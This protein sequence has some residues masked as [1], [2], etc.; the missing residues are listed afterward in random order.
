VSHRDLGRLRPAGSPL[1]SEACGGVAQTSRRARERD[2][3][4]I[5]E[6][7]KQRPKAGAR[8]TVLRSDAVANRKRL[9]DAAAVAIRRQ[10]PKVPITTIANDA[11]VG[12]GTLYRHFPTRVALL[13]ALAERSYRLVLEHAREAAESDQSAIASVGAFF[14]RTITRRDDLILPLHGGP[15]TLDADAIALRTAISD[16]LEAVLRRGR[17]DGTIRRD[18]TAADIIIAGAQLAEP[19]A[20]APDWD[21]IARRQ[22]GIILAGLAATTAPALAGRGMTRADLESALTKPTKLREKA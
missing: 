19:L 13:T 10:G 12:V 21:L 8:R 3:G 17:K 15:V 11:G 4:T 1:S 6:M 2:A 20:H 18:V 5:S 7:A 9:L 14:E 22:A 16:A